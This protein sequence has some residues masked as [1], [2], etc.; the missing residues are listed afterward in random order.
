MN[1]KSP[2]VVGFGIENREQFR[3]ITNYAAGA[4]VGSAFLRAIENAEDIRQ[5]TRD[6]VAEFL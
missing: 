3:E 4:I 6:F 5:A 1:L 2:L